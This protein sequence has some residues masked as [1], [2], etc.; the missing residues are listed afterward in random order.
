MAHGHRGRPGNHRIVDLSSSV[1]AVLPEP[2][3]T[4][5]R[6]LFIGNLDFGT[7]PDELREHF[8]AFGRVTDVQTRRDRNHLHSIAFLT[9]ASEEAAKFALAAKAHVLDGRELTV[10]W[11]R[12]GS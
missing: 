2:S 1:D 7:T 3:G 10:A 4:R 12:D 8:D 6:K 11:A 9:F 5:G